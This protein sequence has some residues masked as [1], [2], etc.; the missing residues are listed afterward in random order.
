MN[1]AFLKGIIVP[2][3]TP[4]DENERINEVKL[5]QQVD[6]VIKGGVSGILAFGSNGE[7]Y[8]VEE[9][10]QELVLKIILDQTAGRV[11]VFMGIGAIS[12]K[13]CVRIAHMAMEAGATAI[14]VLQPMFLKPTEDE[15]F[16]HFKVIAESVPTMP[17][18]LYNNPGRTSYTLTADLVERLAHEVPN[19]VGMKDSSGDMTLTEEFI[20]RNKDVDFKVFGGK[21]T[22]IYACMCVGAYGCVCTTANFVPELICSI[23]DMY[24]AGD[25]DGSREAQFLLNPIRLAM[26]K[27]SF[28]VA[29]KDYCNLMGLNV[30]A[31]YA[32][33]KPA[34]GR[35]RE[36]LIEQMKLAGYI[37]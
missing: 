11:P 4:I 18:L 30:G 28:P 27:S 8:M 26:D 12:T 22:L 15:L 5:R 25:M 20:R 14:S 29:T 24:I 16:T 2:I 34:C 17:V 10:D 36:L 1:T 35:G 31:P 32:P 9:A 37:K 7:F 21:D 6:Y 3:I 33:N 13:K 23:Y 19:I